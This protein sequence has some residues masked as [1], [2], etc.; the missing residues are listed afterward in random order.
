VLP[1]SKQ[2]YFGYVGFL[3]LRTWRGLLLP[4]REVV[5]TSLGQSEWPTFQQYTRESNC[6][7]AMLDSQQWRMQSPAVSRSCFPLN[8]SNWKTYKSMKRKLQVIKRM[9]KDY[10]YLFWDSGEVC[11]RSLISARPLFPVDDTI[12]RSSDAIVWKFFLTWFWRFLEWKE[13]L[14]VSTP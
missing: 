4:L 5:Q 8:I 7:I 1:G 11:H 2:G 9:K 10:K 13:G 12:D 3:C 14:R 6:H